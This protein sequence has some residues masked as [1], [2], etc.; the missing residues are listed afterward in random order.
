MDVETIS[1][2]WRLNVETRGPPGVQGTPGLGGTEVLLP[3]V[4]NT[5][6]ETK[7]T[8]TLSEDTPT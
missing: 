2:T 3:G 5:L 7:T 8:D 4:S 1:T 6:F